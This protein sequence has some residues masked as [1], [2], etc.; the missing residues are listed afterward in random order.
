MTEDEGTRGEVGSRGATRGKNSGGRWCR[1]A[2]G[3][4]WST[5][6]STRRARP[7]CWSAR[8]SRSSRPVHCLR[9][10]PPCYCK[11]CAAA[12]CCLRHPSAPTCWSTST[13]TAPPR[14]AAPSPGPPPRSGAAS[15]TT[16]R[17]APALTYHPDPTRPDPPARR[18]TRPDR[19]Y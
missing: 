1:R 10:A 12:G 9:A 6:R 2:G 13:S 5:S 14:A 11:S 8:W 7:G 17:L 16:S 4:C 18:Q 15:A 19:P 3:R